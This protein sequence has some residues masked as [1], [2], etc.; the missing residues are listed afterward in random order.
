MT[1]LT[2]NLHNSLVEELTSVD[3]EHE[4]NER[5]N[6]VQW[7]WNTGETIQRYIMMGVIEPH[8]RTGEG[9]DDY[10]TQLS[11]DVNRGK[12]KLQ[13]CL[14]F[15]RMIPDLDLLLDKFGKDL[16]ISTIN[17]HILPK[18]GDGQDLNE[19]ANLDFYE[20]KRQKQKEV[21][22]A[23]RLTTYQQQFVYYSQ[24]ARQASEYPPETKVVPLDLIGDRL[25]K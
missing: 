10:L 5:I 22:E 15:F 3:T 25:S 17:D 7:A 16:N 8:S 11:K 12:R 21:V 23:E 14:Q 20:E 13:Q 4:Y 6:R 2:Q 24:N 1:E 18:L 19:I 9:L